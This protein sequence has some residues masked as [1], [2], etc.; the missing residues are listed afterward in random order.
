MTNFDRAVVIRKLQAITKY[1]QLL[2]D[3]ASLTQQAYLDSVEQQLIVERLLHLI[4]EAAVDTNSYLLVSAN[5]PPPETYFNSFIQVGQQ[6]IISQPL[7]AQLAPS[8]GLRNRL[9]H[10]YE[11]IDSAIVFQA[12]AFALTLYPE[13][14]KQIQAYLERSE[15]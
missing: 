10:E 3:R 7:A 5:Q 15:P 12:I 6:R 2:S 14:V 1:L 13:Y 9:V 8:A 4:V 11:E